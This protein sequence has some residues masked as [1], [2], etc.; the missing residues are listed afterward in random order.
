MIKITVDRKIR[1]KLHYL[2]K[3]RDKK[4]RGYF[5]DQ[6]IVFLQLV[7]KKFCLLVSFAFYSPD[8]KLTQWQ[9]EVK[10]LKK[11]S[12]AK[13]DRP[14]EPKRLLGYPKKY[15]LALQL[16]KNFACEFPVFKV[17]CVLAD[18]LYGNSLFVDGI[19]IIWPGVQIITQLRKNQKVMQG[20]KSLSWQEFFAFYKG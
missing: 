20:E 15:T 12:V 13:K 14:K 10:K 3:I 6:N 4:T 1:K 17:S 19:E 7:T 16:L 18:A 9:Q 5:C 2:H 11:L 8:L